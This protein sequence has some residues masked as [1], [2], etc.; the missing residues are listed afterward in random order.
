[1]AAFL[2]VGAVVTTVPELIAVAGVPA[3]AVGAGVA[4]CRARARLLATGWLAG[5]RS[6]LLGLS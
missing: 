2:T 3:L 6:R 1:V 4:G 5:G